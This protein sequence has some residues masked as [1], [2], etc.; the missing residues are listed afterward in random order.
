MSVSGV[1]VLAYPRSAYL[2]HFVPCD[3]ESRHRRALYEPVQPNWVTPD[4]D[5]LKDC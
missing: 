2:H 4:V 1:E 3:E 5:P